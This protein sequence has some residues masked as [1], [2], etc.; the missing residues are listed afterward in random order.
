MGQPRAQGLRC[1][2]LRET[3]ACWKLHSFTETAQEEQKLNFCPKVTRGTP[4]VAGE[5]IIKRTL[6]HPIRFKLLVW[7]SE[8][9]QM[10]ALRR[11]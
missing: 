2:I 8:S 11:K 7:L 5:W 1:F 9:V 4:K 3:E 6:T 10:N